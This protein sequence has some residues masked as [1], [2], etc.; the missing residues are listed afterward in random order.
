MCKIYAIANQKGGVG[1]TTLTLNLGASLAKMGKRVCL[2]DC[3]PQANMTMALG[4]QQPDELPVTMPDV[5]QEIIKSDF[6]AETSALL[7]GRGYVLH[8]QGVDFIPSSIGLANVENLLINAMS[9]ENVLKKLV[10]HIKGDYEYILLDTMPSLNFVTINAL[11]A[12]DRVLI[13]VQPQ[14][15]SVKGLELLFDTIRNVKRNLNPTL[16]IAGALVTMY[17]SRIGF[18]REVVN[19]VEE[20]YGE[21]FR[22]FKAKIPVS[23]KATESQARSMS[24]FE[25]DP[26]GKIAANYERFVR[27]LLNNE[28]GCE[29]E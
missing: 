14:F 4:Y 17:D 2:I 5:M 11:N 13:P 12:A 19:V 18:H 1:K 3:D 29:H 26:T 28:R 15:F 6:D 8:S 16:E 21:H 20:A 7:Q 23:I 24:I 10:N 9:R 27:E 25:H 22:V